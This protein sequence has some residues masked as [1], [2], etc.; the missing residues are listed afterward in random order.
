MKRIAILTA[1]LLA[2]VS[3]FGQAARVDIPL[4]T[5]GPSVPITGGPLPQA[6]WVANAAAYLC[7]H[8]S[9]TL[10]A[11]QAH[12]ITTYTDSTE[13]TTCPTATPLVQL[14][15]NTCT[16]STGTAANVGFWYG[17]GLFDYWIV[18][19]YGTYGPFSGNS[20]NS[21]LPSSCGNPIGI[22]CGGTGA[23]TAAGANLNITGVT[24]TGTLG[25]S[26]Q[27]S[28]FPGTLAAFAVVANVNGSINP[29][30]PP[31]NALCDGA[32][33]DRVAI[34][35]ALTAAG[36]QA[37][38][39]G[40][41]TLTFPFGRTCL[42]NSNPNSAV[43][44]NVIELVPP[45]VGINGFGTVKV[46][47]GVNFA[48]L[49]SWGSS[50]VITPVTV[51]DLTIDFNGANN[52]ITTSPG[53]TNY[54]L[55]FGNNL[56][57]PNGS[58]GLTF[59]NLTFKNGN[60]VWTIFTNNTDNAVVDGCH[61][62]NWGINS[63]IQYDSSLIYTNGQNGGS[64][65]TNN[66]FTASGPAVRTA[67]EVHN[68]NTVVTGNRIYGFGVGI[69]YDSNP[70]TLGA[71]TS[72][73][74]ISNNVI[75]ANDLGISFWT[76][77]GAID[78]LI[79]AN[80]NISMDRQGFSTNWASAGAEAGIQWYGSGGGY[81]L[82]H[83]KITGNVITWAPETATFPA[84][85][86]LA[87]V[88]LNDIAASTAVII[89][90]DVSNNIVSNS[91]Y[92]CYLFSATAI[93]GLHIHNNIAAN[94][95]MEKGAVPPGVYGS[96]YTF[97]VPSGD[98]VANLLVDHNVV[99]DTQTT[100]TTQTGII[101]YGAVGD[102]APT[103]AQIVDNSITFS[104]TST[105]AY[106][107]FV[108]SGPLIRVTA[109]GA[110][111]YGRVNPGG[112]TSGNYSPIGSTITDSTTGIIYTNTNTNG[113]T[114][115]GQSNST[116][117]VTSGT[118]VNANACNGPYTVSMTGVTTGMTFQVTATSDTHAVTGWGAPAAGIL[119][120]TDYPTAGTFNYY[121]CNNSASSITTSAAV[122]FNVSAR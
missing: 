87:G 79:V 66:D 118:V 26:S 68:S 27:V 102:G 67:I 37:A 78:N 38:S 19:S 103:G 10:V 91:P 107:D 9:T 64:V 28:T 18:S 110:F 101:W 40:K 6:L 113:L 83:A 49:F 61:W 92:A 89:D 80:N 108:N 88:S 72:N 21:A 93:K 114:W 48:Q 119:Y 122:T 44:N 29:M 55:A 12:P 51:E 56:G 77:N 53:Y 96:G 74:N 112:S 32:T 23:T 57:A 94:C 47:N 62:L 60:G 42:I 95:N 115:A 81:S 59:R 116:L 25:T 46:G 120:I 76:D 84:P 121:V 111:S 90:S 45:G 36:V 3:A 7:T 71:T 105:N 5:A 16:A 35:A 98:T 65:I 63:S 15:G 99:Y 39:T 109:P 43:A 4:L 2:A 8:P 17:G 106:A 54:R 24:Q 30:A 50:A 33:D 20:S 11:C 41:A 1:L 58:S 14:P 117:T 73:I 69:I 13:G 75:Y 31:Y 34:Q 70:Y 104:P 82:S 22:P 97:I 52:P 85:Y 100:P 86:N